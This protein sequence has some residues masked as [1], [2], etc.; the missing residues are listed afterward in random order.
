MLKNA[1][2]ITQAS[3]ALRCVTILCT[4]AKYNIL[5]EIFVEIV[6]FSNLGRAAKILKIQ[7]FYMQRFGTCKIMWNFH[8]FPVSSHNKKSSKSN[9]NNNNNN[10]NKRTTDRESTRGVAS[11]VLRVES[12]RTPRFGAKQRP[13]KAT[14]GTT[15]LAS[16]WFYVMPFIFDTYSATQPALLQTQLAAP[17]L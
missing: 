12:Q 8:K 5:C 2:E 16:T 11:N 9:N 10:N 17:L 15:R 13:S 1:C 4:I 14:V 6:C 3:A 7:K